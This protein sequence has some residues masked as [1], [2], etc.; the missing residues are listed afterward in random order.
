MKTTKILAFVLAIATL[1][2][3]AGCGM[4]SGSS[5]GGG[6]KQTTI[7]T[8]NGTVKT[9]YTVQYGKEATVDVP[10][11]PGYYFD[12]FYS[13][14]E[15]GDKYFDITGKSSTIWLEGL[16]S[17]F[18]AQWNPISELN[19]EEEINIEDPVTWS[20]Y[21]SV[22][23][24]FTLTPEIK[25]AIKGN[26]DKNVKIT[27]SFDL[28]DASRYSRTDMSFTLA[29][30]HSSGKENVYSKVWDSS[31]ATNY[32]HFSGETTTTAR[33]FLKEGKVCGKLSKSYGYDDHYAIKNIKITFEFVD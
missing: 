11:K 22:S 1:L 19:F 17:V 8:Y 24:T 26:L 25:N 12:G 27:Y 5:V 32:T 13:S 20:G 23:F 10:A 18:Y 6:A 28:K 16:P 14:E 31:S 9:D 3:F 15:G 21:G 29:N 30:S 7:S 2:C 33:K 4:F